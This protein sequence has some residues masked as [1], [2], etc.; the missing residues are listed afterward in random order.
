MRLI[1]A[2]ELFNKL[3]NSGITP[4]LV[5]TGGHVYKGQPELSSIGKQIL[6]DSYNIPESNV[7][8]E[9][10]LNTVE[11][12]GIIASII[13]SRDIP[14]SCV[15]VISNEYHL[16]AKKL[17]QELGISFISAEELLIQRN[18]RYRRVI[19]DICTS[20][21]YLRLSKSQEIRAKVVNF[22]MGRL[23][24]KTAD[25]WAKRGVKLTPFNHSGLRDLSN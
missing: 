21:H 23:I 5:V 16:T 4:R 25:R 3:D 7:A 6:V 24:Y 11:E 13:K 8:T 14:S 12:F 19:Q 15:A 17:A 1:A 10:G 9:A 2:V 18:R 22:P 20:D